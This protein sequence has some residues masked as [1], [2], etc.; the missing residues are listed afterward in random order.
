MHFERN[1]D[2]PLETDVIIV[3]EMSMVDIQ[4]F[5]ALLKARPA[6][7]LKSTSPA[8]TGEDT[9]HTAIPPAAS[10]DNTDKTASKKSEQGTSSLPTVKV[11][12]RIAELFSAHPQLTD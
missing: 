6:C 5:Q 1:E 3:D 8:V 10:P 11:R 12:F 2:N 7:F 4:L 9:S